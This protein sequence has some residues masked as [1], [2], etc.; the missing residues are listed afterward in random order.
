MEMTE[1]FLQNNRLHDAD[2]FNSLI[3]L[4][5]LVRELLAQEQYED[6]DRVLRYTIEHGYL[7]GFSWCLGILQEEFTREDCA[8][9]E[10]VCVLGTSIPNYDSFLE[11]LQVDLTQPR[12]DTETVCDK[13]GEVTSFF[14]ILVY[15][16]GFDRIHFVSCENFDT[17]DN[18]YVQY[19]LVVS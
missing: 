16:T 7:E 15:Q 5:T 8:L 1:K 6:L 18:D 10:F 11:T 17:K 9:P 14:N 19:K 3:E 2:D 12:N 13:N 4:A